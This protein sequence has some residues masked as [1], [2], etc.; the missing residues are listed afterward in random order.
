MFHAIHAGDE[1]KDIGTALTLLHK[2]S[3]TL[4]P[5]N[6]ALYKHVASMHNQNKDSTKIKNETMISLCSTTKEATVKSHR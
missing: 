1:N 6:S 5:L 2:Y 4:M 3:A